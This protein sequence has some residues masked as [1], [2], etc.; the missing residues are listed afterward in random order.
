MTDSITAAAPPTSGSVRSLLRLG[1]I[2]C[3]RIAQVAHLPAAAKS[4]A[5]RLVAVSDPSPVLSSLVGAR[6]GADSYTN[7]DTLLARA[8]LDAVVVAIPD[9]FHRDVTIAALDRGLPVLAEK[10]AATTAVEARELLAAAEPTG[11]AVQIGAMRRHDPGLQFARAAVGSVGEVLSAAFWYRLPSSLRASTEAALFPAQ[12]V[13]AGVRR[14]EAGFKSDRESYLLRTHGAHVFDTVRY[15][16]GEVSAVTTER[17]QLGA[18]LHWQ[19]S[20]RTDLGLA[21]FAITANVHADYSEGIEIFGSRGRIRVRSYFPFYRRAST[22]AVFDEER[23]LWSTTEFGAVDPYQRQLE[24][25]AAAVRDGTPCD[26][27]LRDGLRAL[28]V[29]EAAARSAASDGA[30]VTP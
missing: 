19:G 4:D 2:G 17:V 15:L 16:L 9:R 27:D 14:I 18:D 24:S 20:L 29:I 6:Y 23:G 12:V 1:V 28:E 8:D 11:L 10:P 25:F 7:T 21:S 3:G 22:A 26:P 30:R 5:V 13:D